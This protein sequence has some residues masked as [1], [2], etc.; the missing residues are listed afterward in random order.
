MTKKWF[1]YRSIN[2]FLWCLFVLFVI[3]VA[4]RGNPNVAQW[5]NEGAQHW[6]H[7]LNLYNTS[8]LAIHGSHSVAGTGFIYLPQSAILYIPFS[9][10]PPCLSRIVWRLALIALLAVMFV[11]I[12][13]IIKKY[14]QF[15]NS[16]LLTSVL[17]FISCSSMLT[18]QMNVVLVVF[19]FFGAVAVSKEQWKRAAFFLVFALAAKPTAIVILL[20]ATGCYR[21]IQKPVIISL[22]IMLAF[23]FAFGHPQYVI[24]QYKHSVEML[25]AANDIGVNSV[26]WS[27]LFGMIGQVSDLMVN[28]EI[29]LIIRLVFAISTF[30]LM[31]FIHRRYELKLSAFFLF[32]LS[33]V[34]LM[35]FNPRTEANDYIQLAPVLMI[36]ISFAPIKHIKL[37]CYV[38]IF[39]G[40]CLAFN[41]DISRLI[42]SNTHSWVAPLATILLCAY[43]IW[44]KAWS[45][46]TQVSCRQEKSYL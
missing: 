16:A 9:L 3:F 1:S 37:H 15:E 17:L 27:Q 30:L 36:L 29:Q 18:G 32:A 20:L 28:Q 35:L 8:K 2:I 11:Q 26:R 34:Y 43:L 4:I 25:F 40:F 44:N 33:S 6:I 46:M 41:G 23:P 38:L 5:Y 45:G 39:I 22:I 13:R 24:D 10:L 19:T 31:L 7:G 14:T 12:E 42:I 21:Q